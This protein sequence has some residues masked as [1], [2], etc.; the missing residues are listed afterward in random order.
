[1][2]FDLRAAVT[3]RQEGKQGATAVGGKEDVGPGRGRGRG[4]RGPPRSGRGRG[5]GREGATRWGRSLH[6]CALPAEDT[7]MGLRADVVAGSTTPPPHT[8]T[9][10]PTHSSPRSGSPAFPQRAHL[11]GSG[12]DGGHDQRGLP[13]L[14]GVVSGRDTG[15]VRHAHGGAGSSN[16]HAVACVVAGAI[17]P[18]QH[19]ERGAGGHGLEVAPSACTH[20]PQWVHE[21]FAEQC[22]MAGN[23][24]AG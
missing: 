10:P 20:G 14:G 3:C 15:R 9:H 18:V 19:L 12:R 23:G 11:R 17:R 4:T 7:P 24:W 5:A 8:H 1:M 22:P 21:A 13:A 2:P 16:V 6:A